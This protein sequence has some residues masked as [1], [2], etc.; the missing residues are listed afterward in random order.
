MTVMLEAWTRALP[1]MDLLPI[2]PQAKMTAPTERY[3]K[4]VAAAAAGQYPKDMLA[5]GEHPG[6]GEAQQWL[7]ALLKAATAAEA[8]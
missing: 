8:K 5:M 4:R 2:L 6:E 1:A 3:P 7:G